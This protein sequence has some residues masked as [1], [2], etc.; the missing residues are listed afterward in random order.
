MVGLWVKEINIGND[1]GHFSITT[2]EK[3][4]LRGFLL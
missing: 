4:V 1:F 3:D 2:L